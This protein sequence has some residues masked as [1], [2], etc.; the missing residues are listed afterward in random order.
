MSDTIVV[1]KDGKIQHIGKVSELTKSDSKRIK[2][3]RNGKYENFLYEGN[4]NDLYKELQGYDITDILIEN[5]SLDEI[6]MHYYKD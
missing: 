2:I 5:P 3:V 1:M 4:L 6:F